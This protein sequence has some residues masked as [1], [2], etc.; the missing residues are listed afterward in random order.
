MATVTEEIMEEVKAPIKHKDEDAV[1]TKIER[2]TSKIPSGTFLA[3]G[4]AV[5]GVSAALAL[6]G[7]VRQANFVGM[8]VPTILILGLYNKLVKQNEPV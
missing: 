7:R 3:A 4:M 5:I 2:A 6:S 1:T 8:W